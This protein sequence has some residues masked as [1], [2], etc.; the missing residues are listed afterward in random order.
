MCVHV[1][2]CVCVW[3]G[4]SVSVYVCVCMSVRANLFYFIE[5]SHTVLLPVN[6]LMYNNEDQVILRISHWDE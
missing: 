2:V 5:L 1:C 3:R 4:G 6:V